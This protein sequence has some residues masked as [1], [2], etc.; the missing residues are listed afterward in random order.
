MYRDT[1]IS[2][3]NTNI[4]VLYESFCINKSAALSKNKLLAGLIVY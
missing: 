4:G 1:H 3:L 2:A